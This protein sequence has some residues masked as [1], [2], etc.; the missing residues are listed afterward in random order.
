MGLR[1][2]LCR[3]YFLEIVEGKDYLVQVF[4]ETGGLGTL[5][6]PV[7]LIIY[8]SKLKGTI[9]NSWVIRGL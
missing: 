1:V 5:D 7:N 6:F 3:H 4:T 8:K 9:K 2:I